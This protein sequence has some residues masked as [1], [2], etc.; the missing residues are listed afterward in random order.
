M[1]GKAH[2]SKTNIVLLLLIVFGTS[3]TIYS[4]LKL[5]SITGPTALAR[6]ING[7]AIIALSDRFVL[8]DQ[9]GK[10]E[11]S[12]MYADAGLQGKVVDIQMLSEGEVMVGDGGQNALLRC[13]DALLKCRRLSSAENVYQPGRFFKFYVDEAKEKIILTNTEKHELVMLN[14]RGELIRKLI[15]KSGALEFPDGI[16]SVSPE[17]TYL[18]NSLGKEVLEVAYTSDSAQIKARHST[19]SAYAKLGRNLPMSIT[20]VDNGDWWVAAQDNSASGDVS[21]LLVFDSKWNAK[22]SIEIPEMV[23]PVAV[24][25]LDSILLVADMA[26][27]NLF[28]LDQEGNTVDQFVDPEIIDILARQK[29]M[30]N[31][32]NMSR[33][34][35]IM[36]VLVLLGYALV[37]E[38]KRKKN[39]P[40]LDESNV[41]DNV[42]LVIDVPGFIPGLFRILPVVLIILFLTAGILLKGSSPTLFTITAL[43]W[44]PII[45][46][47]VWG[48]NMATRHMPERLEVRNGVLIVTMPRGEILQ[49]R[50][51]EVQ[52]T[53]NIIWIGDKYI[54]LGNG[55]AILNKPKLYKK[56]MAMLSVAKKLSMF[57]AQMRLIRKEK[58][59]YAWVLIVIVIS[60]GGYF[61]T[62][63]ADLKKETQVMHEVLRQ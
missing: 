52:Y 60:A 49:S 10:V 13:D 51:E 30:Q 59:F 25:S 61:G 31:L 23:N 46:L 41:D 40:R 15:S 11:K 21:A 62:H 19:V 47:L 44:A 45:L 26:G 1:Q 57:D 20:R 22:A 34:G 9:N 5:N 42:L 37:L 39:E 58:M 17:S 38:Q 48:T 36:F 2:T 43:I 63:Y 3:L 24:L 55:G 50:L 12:T 18:A 54:N 53:Q 4:S 28:A 8:L 56:L 35:S 16:Y 29:N 32:F 27:F 7:S 33:Y 6:Q 14:M